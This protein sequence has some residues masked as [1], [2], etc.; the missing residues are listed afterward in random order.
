MTLI[1]LKTMRYLDVL[2]VLEEVEKSAERPGLKER[3]W[4]HLCDNGDIYRDSLTYI[5]TEDSYADLVEE[6]GEYLGNDLEAIKQA[7]THIPEDDI[8]WFATW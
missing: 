4:T 5:N 2:E 3:V 6:H 1:K 8:I 7:I